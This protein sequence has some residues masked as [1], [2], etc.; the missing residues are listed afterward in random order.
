[1]NKH[2]PGPWSLA[3]DGWIEG[4]SGEDVV[5]YAGCGTHEAEWNSADLRLALAAPEL[6][7][8]LVALLAERSNAAQLSNAG[9]SARAAIEKATGESA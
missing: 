4:P 5:C 1:M 8:A 6:L 3:R 2:T 7:A 9:L